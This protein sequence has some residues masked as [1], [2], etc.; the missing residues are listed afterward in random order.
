[1]RRTA[2]ALILAATALA[3]CTSS[4]DADPSFDGE[5]EAVANVLDDLTEAAVDDNGER[6]CREILAKP[7]RDKLGTRCAAAM[8][9]AF[10]DADVTDLTVDSVRVSGDT[11]RAQVDS[12]R[13]EERGERR[14]LQF[15]REGRDWRIS[16]LSGTLQ[17]VS[18]SVMPSD[19]ACARAAI[20]SAV[21]PDCEIVSTSVS[22]CGTESR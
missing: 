8:V 21:S 19:F 5:E 17:I 16:A 14:T 18:V 4:G 11:A 7:L 15:V 10:D 20:V 9:Q 12:G 6:V 2:L 13:D 3:G 1:M 22:G